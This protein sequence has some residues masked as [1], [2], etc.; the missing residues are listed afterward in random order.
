[1]SFESLRIGN[2]GLTAAQKA[3]D[4]TSRNLANAGN[5]VYSRQRILLSPVESGTGPGDGVRVLGVERIRDVLA[6]LTFRTEAGLAQSN[7]LRA[8]ALGRVE[9]GIGP[10]AGNLPSLVNEMFDAFNQLSMAPTDP[11]GRESVINASSTVA[12]EFNRLYTNLEDLSRD[13][14]ANAADL[15]ADLNSSLKQVASLNKVIAEAE[16]VSVDTSSLKDERD[17]ALDHLAELVGA[18]TQTG[19]G[20]EMQVIIG[21]YPGVTGEIPNS[22]SLSGAGTSVDPLRLTSS[23]GVTVP[24]TGGKLGGTLTYVNSDTL[25]LQAEL[26]AAAIVVRDQLNTAHTAGFDLNGAA[27]LNLFTGTGAWDMSLNA[28]IGIDEVAASASGAPGDGN[29]ALAISQ[30]RQDTSPTGALGATQAY[31]V[32][33][34]SRTQAAARTAEIS[35]NVADGARTTRR[36]ISGVNIDEELIDLIRYQ[37]AYQASAMA[38]TTANEVLDTLINR[39]LR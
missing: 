12:G 6:D 24:V 7:S 1:M 26:N 30:L 14:Q 34:G 11:A 16:A 23:T 32:S 4:V 20:G 3:L 29:N 8:D 35:Q 31:V 33:V 21:N 27:G 5:E 19:L 13:M 36:E 37:R 22:F 17:S 25:A 28:A 9:S 2:S 10:L 39:M 15:V 18:R 38:V